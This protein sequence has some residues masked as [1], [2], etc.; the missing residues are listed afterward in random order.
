MQ[1]AEV[2]SYEQFVQGVKSLEDGTDGPLKF[3]RSTGKAVNFA[4]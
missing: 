1:D 3:F 4:N 2:E